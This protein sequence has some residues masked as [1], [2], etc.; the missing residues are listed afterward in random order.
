MENLGQFYLKSN[1]FDGPKYTIE[2]LNR[3]VSNHLASF[4]FNNIEVYQSKGTKILSLET[5]DLFQKIVVEK[6]GGYCFEQNKLMYEV[7]KDLK[8]NVSAHLGRVVYNR[9]IDAPRT[10]RMTILNLNNQLYL[11]DVGFGPYTPN[12]IIA[13]NGEKTNILEENYY[14]KENSGLYTLIVEKEEGPF[15]LY[16]FDL[17]ACQESDF[18]LGNYYTNTHPNSKFVNELIIS[19]KDDEKIVF[20]SANKIVT[21]KNKNRSEIDVSSE[22]ELKKAIEENFSLAL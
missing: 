9:E 2:F 16:T 10:H 22:E 18:E 1:N 4:P 12:R 8:F 6:R 21:L 15:S 20:Y 17:N 7:L 13:L 11:V 14:I 5:K 19:K 3:L